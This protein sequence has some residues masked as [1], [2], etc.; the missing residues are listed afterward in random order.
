[1]AQGNTIAR[2]TTRFVGAPPICND[3]ITINDSAKLLNQK[4]HDRKNQNLIPFSIS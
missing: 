3:Q 1:M 4:L 2:Q